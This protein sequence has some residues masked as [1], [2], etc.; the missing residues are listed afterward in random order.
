MGADLYTNAA[1]DMNGARLLEAST[2]EVDRASGA[3]DQMTLSKGWAGKSPGSRKMTIKVTNGVLAAGWE[4]D[5]GAS[6]AGLKI[7][8]FTIYAGQSFLTST[9]FIISD[10]F[11]KGVDQNASYEFTIE[12]EYALWNSNATTP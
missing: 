7:N 12:A 11:K 10:S 1:I 8:S 2:V 4:F 3:V 9:G 5:A 6:I